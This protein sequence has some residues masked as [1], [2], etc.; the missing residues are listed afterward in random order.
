MNR[1]REFFYGRTGFDQLNQAII[2]IGAV[3]LFF[4]SILNIAPLAFVFLLSIIICLY[5]ALSTDLKTRQWENRWMLEKISKPAAF[6]RL[7]IR[8]LREIRTH[9]YLK[10][11]NCKARLRVPRGKGKVSIRCAKCD[12]G[13]IKKV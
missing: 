12:V 8:M 3:F 1:L 10:C 7:R 9:R 2:I 13:F 11:P 4:S 6:F 5:R